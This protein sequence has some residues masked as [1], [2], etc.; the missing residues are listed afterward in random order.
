MKASLDTN[1]I[2]HLYRANCQSILFDFFNEG[3]LI[4]E[5]I[6]NHELNN[7]GKDIL[8]LVDSD[9]KSGKIKLYSE[10]DLDSLKVLQVFTNN[11]KE[12]KMLYGTGDLGEVYAISLAQT[13]GICSLVTNDTKQGG[14]YMSLLQFKDD[15][16][17]FNFCDIL[18]LRYLFN[19][20][21]ENKTINDFNIINE[22]S[23]LEWSF[24]SQLKKFINRF[25]IAQ[26]RDEDKE[27]ITTLKDQNQV[28]IKEKLKLLKEEIAKFTN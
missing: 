3:I 15:V 20:V 26:Y 27:W 11:F 28:N 19:G 24:I 4:H 21:N 12:N 13:L 2:I 14:P 8:N 22:T 7:H 5:Y 25:F 6:R 10:Q 23:N 18:I 9:I 1:I 17:P 16:M